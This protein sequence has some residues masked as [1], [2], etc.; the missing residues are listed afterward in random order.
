[1]SVSRKSKWELRFLGSKGSETVGNK[2]IIGE[3]QFEYYLNFANLTIQVTLHHP[4]PERQQ[5]IYLHPSY[6]GREVIIQHS[7]ISAHL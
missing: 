3:E 7:Y 4:P 6:A 2:T 1:M 5:F